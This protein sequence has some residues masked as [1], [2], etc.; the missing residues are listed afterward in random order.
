MRFFTIIPS[1]TK[2]DFIGKFKPFLIGSAALVAF[3]VYEIATKGFNYGIDFTG[4][5]VFL[6]KFD[7]AQS[8]DAVRNRL[9]D[10]GSPDASVVATGTTQTEYLVTS[11]TESTD[12]LHKRFIAKG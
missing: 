1:N 9:R 11:R 3:I 5:T 10:V 6:V 12:T 7:S 8:A 4:G 2:F